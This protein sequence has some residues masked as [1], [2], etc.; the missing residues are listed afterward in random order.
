[1]IEVVTAAAWMVIV[2]TTPQGVAIDSIP[3]PS[4]TACEAAAE[5]LPGT[6]SFS[7]A[8][9]VHYCIKGD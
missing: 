6:W 2:A 9:I 3:M 4:L 8:T 1:M 7:T 5:V